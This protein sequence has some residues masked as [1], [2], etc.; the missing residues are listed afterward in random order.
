MKNGQKFSSQQADHPTYEAAI[1]DA[2]KDLCMKDGNLIM[3]RGSLLQKARHIVDKQGFAYRKGK[4]RSLELNPEPSRKRKYVTSEVKS[5]HVE[6]LQVNIA[7]LEETIELLEKQKQ[8]YIGQ[9]KFL[10]AAETNSSIDEK[11][12]QKQ[13]IMEELLKL[14][15]SQKRP[16]KK[17]KIGAKNTM[18]ASS[19]FQQEDDTDL[20]RSSEEDASFIKIH[21]KLQVCCA[22]QANVYWITIYFSKPSTVSWSVL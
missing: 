20:S 11:R 14:T 15:G 2:C 12:Q 10:L 7:S 22:S 9:D 4:S 6:D 18:G 19:F 1:N 8:V 3:N 13:K 17:R 5:K 21:E 16:K